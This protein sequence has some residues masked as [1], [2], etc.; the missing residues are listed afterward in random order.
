M[1]LGPGGG[2]LLRTVRDLVAEAVGFE[3]TVTRRPQRLSRPSHSSALARFRR[4]TL[5]ARGRRS[6]THT[7]TRRAGSL[8]SSRRGAYARQAAV[9]RR[10]VSSSTVG[11]AVY[12][13]RKWSRC[14]DAGDIDS[15]G[16][17]S[18]P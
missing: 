10:T 12:G 15:P 14:S 7:T 11:S 18:T 13:K 4:A 9:R 2:G 17:I 5:A 16:M 6:G 8:G 1:Q 3:P